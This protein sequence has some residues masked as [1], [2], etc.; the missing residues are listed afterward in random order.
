MQAWGKQQWI[1]HI[2][3]YL[4]HGPF[5]YRSFLPSNATM[6][7]A[8]DVFRRRGHKVDIFFEVVEIG[9]P[10]IGFVIFPG[11]ESTDITIRLDTTVQDV[12]ER[13][14]GC[15]IV[16]IRGCG[17]TID[18]VVQVVKMAICRGWYVE[19]TNMGTLVKL[20]NDAKHR[21]TTLMVTLCRTTSPNTSA[22]S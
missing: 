3:T 15:Q 11:I 7:F 19:K 6:L 4:Q 20:D 18:L 16:R 12:I 1:E 14:M 17:T 8:V 13:M 22:S 9:P 5:T 10:C 21:N 2:S